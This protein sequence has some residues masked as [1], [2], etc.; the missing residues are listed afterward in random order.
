[1][2]KSFFT[3]KRVRLLSIT[4][5]V[6]I[7]FT[8]TTI[9]EGW[10]TLCS[11]CPVGLLEVMAAAKLMF[12]PKYLLP[13]FLVLSMVVVLGKFFC[14]WSCPSTLLKNVFNGKK[15]KSTSTEK[16]N[17]IVND[18]QCF[19][20]QKEEAKSEA[21]LG[22]WLSPKYVGYGFMGGALIAS[23]IVG[24]PVFC[25]ICPI[26]LFFGFVFALWKVSTIYQ[27]GWELIL[28][29]TILIIELLILRSW[30]SVICPL[31]LLFKVVGEIGILA[32]FSIRPRVS[33]NDCM[34]RQGAVCNKCNRVCPEGI[35]IFE[36]NSKGFGD[37]TVCLECYEACPSGAVKI[38]LTSEKSSP[39]KGVNVK[40][41]I[42]Q[43]IKN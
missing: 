38:Q 11:Y 14:A 18:K 15:Q 5:I 39:I 33:A 13:V 27:P 9:Q 32:G 40:N 41:S 37:C 8:G 26:G 19:A 7:T 36:G 24:F 6:G 35:E 42:F 31:G 25:L 43:E 17:E 16:S 3:L 28:F 23:F 21:R 29:P 20:C 34:T 12:F 1:M 30:C 22:V 4:A 10:G 2:I